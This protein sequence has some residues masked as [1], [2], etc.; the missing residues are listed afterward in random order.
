MNR[1]AEILAVAEALL[2][3]EGPDALTMRRVAE[4]MGIKAPSLYKHVANKDAIEAGLQE[5]ALR[6]LAEWLTPSGQD[7]TALTRRYREWALAH[8]GLYELATRRP[9][10]RD[11]IAPGV[12]A[13]AAAQVVAAV[14]GDEHRARALWA[15]A[16]GLVDL[17]LADRF[18]PGADLDR[19][20]AAAIAPYASQAAEVDRNRSET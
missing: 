13:A 8:P 5:R 17:E 19:T 2:E 3:A 7:L 20:W 18:P 14:G 4:E 16:H 10:R 12:E 15:Q 6:D 11:E 9:L 1:R